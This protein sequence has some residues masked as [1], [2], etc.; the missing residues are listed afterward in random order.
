MMMDAPSK[1]LTWLHFKGGH[2]P[3][4]HGRTPVRCGPPRAAWKR[5]IHFI[6][7]N[8]SLEPAW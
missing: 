1:E 5:E 4:A 6:E 2:D 3:P 7:R 8:W